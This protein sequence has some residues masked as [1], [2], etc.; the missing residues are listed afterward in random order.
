VEA[1]LGQGVVGRSVGEWVK[2]AKEACLFYKIL[3]F[4]FTSFVFKKTY[5]SCAV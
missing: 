5:I 4:R 2:E 3:K 1:R